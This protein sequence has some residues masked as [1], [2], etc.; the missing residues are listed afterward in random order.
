MISGPLTY[1]E[2]DEFASRIADL[3]SLPRTT[4]VLDM[5][6]T[7]GIDA[8]ALGKLVRLSAELA[9]GGQRMEIRGCRPPLY[10][11]LLAARLDRVMRISP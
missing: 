8:S 4:I 9:A 11:K 7:T 10:G 3:A 6:A 2:A 5:S 1:V